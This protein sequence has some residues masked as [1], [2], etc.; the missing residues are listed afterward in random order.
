MWTTSVGGGERGVVG[1]EASHD[2]GSEAGLRGSGAPA[3]G[4][5][6]A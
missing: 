5:S 4:G 6:G 3:N 2:L 1:I